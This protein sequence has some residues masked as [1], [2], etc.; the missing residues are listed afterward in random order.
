MDFWY[1]ESVEAIAKELIPKYHSHLA[2]ASIKYIFKEKSSNVGKKVKLS[3][4]YKLSDKMKFL[5]G[6]IDFLIEIGADQ[7]NQMDEETKISMVDHSLTHL[8]G[9]ESEET[10]E[11]EWSIR[12]HDAE[13][14]S[15]ILARRGCW[16][17][18][19]VK[20]AENIPKASEEKKVMV[21]KKPAD[22]AK[23][24]FEEEK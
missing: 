15:E 16:T 21:V 10:G 2:T 14:F 13:E 22:G 1:A 7:F 9:E 18:D 3:S 20:F 19:L 11:M 17:K 12:S 8:F 5:T 23:F 6:G 24:D 4:E